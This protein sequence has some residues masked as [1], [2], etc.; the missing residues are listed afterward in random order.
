MEN[1]RLFGKLC[2]LHRQM[3]RENTLLMNDYGVTPV[4]M[5]ALIFILKSGKEGKNVCQKDV[6]R[7]V[8]LRPSSVSTLLTKLEKDGLIVRKICNDDARTKYL[9]LTEKG[10]EVCHKD[11]LFMDKCD[12]IIE[13]ALNEEEQQTFDGLLTKIMNAI[14]QK[15]ENI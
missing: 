7:W 8:N 3:L 12:R 15:R 5:H 13:S 9:E 2:Y 4:Q 11:K 10:K 6:E 14:S 1:K